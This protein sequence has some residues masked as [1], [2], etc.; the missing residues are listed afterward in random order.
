MRVLVPIRALTNYMERALGLDMRNARHVR[1]FSCIIQPLA[2]HGCDALMASWNSHTRRAPRGARGT[3]GVPNAL[4]RAKPHPGGPRP[5]PPTWFNGVDE[6]ERA[7]GRPQRRLPENAAASDALFRR[8][9]WLWHQRAQS[10]GMIMGSDP[11]VGWAELNN[12]SY[13]RFITAF[14]C[15]LSFH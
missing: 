12:S 3:G 9:A 4:A 5:R 1:A 11:G 10:V 14:R 7:S 8:P 15:F 13:G 2:Q 6:Y